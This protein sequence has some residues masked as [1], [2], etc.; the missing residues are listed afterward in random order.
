MS[1]R[2]LL[3]EDHPVVRFGVRSLILQHRQD[4]EVG[5][6][7]SL[8]DAM[9]EVTNGVW[10]VVLLDLS[11]SDCTGLEGLVKLRRAAPGTP[12]LI[13]SM[14][15][16]AAY[17]ARALQA[18]AAGYLTK[19]HAT[20]ELLT[21]VER[22][23]A[24]GRYVSSAFADRLAGMLTG[25]SPTAQPHEAL[26]AQEHRVMV[27]IAGGKAPSEIAATMHLSVKTVGTYRARI[28][29]KTGLG[30]TAEIARYCLQHGLI[31]PD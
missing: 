23:R 2:M 21:A 9:R 18:G 7:T 19:E 4:A 12:V 13:L 28:R 25:Q 8:A 30:S 26:S 22:V 11:L 10:D 27:L 1:L 29:E 24:G 20:T 14:H 15:D 17:A 6:A 3:V 5:E 16:E 31:E